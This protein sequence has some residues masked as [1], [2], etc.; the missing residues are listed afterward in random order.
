MLRAVSG[1]DIATR[2]N[3]DVVDGLAVQTCLIDISVQVDADFLYL[4]EGKKSAFI[5]T[6]ASSLFSCTYTYLP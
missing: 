6:L 5:T 2:Q 4:R 3:N 1:I